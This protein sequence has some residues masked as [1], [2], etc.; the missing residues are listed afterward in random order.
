MKIR[1]CVV[2][3][4]ITRYVGHVNVKSVICD[5]FNMALSD[6]ILAHTYICISAN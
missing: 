5:R 2:A 1:L 4:V 3:N 6:R